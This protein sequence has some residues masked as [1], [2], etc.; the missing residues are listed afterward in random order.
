MPEGNSA[1]LP[2]FAGGSIAGRP[3]V[4]G[5]SGAFL[6]AYFS[7]VNANSFQFGFSIFILGMVI[8]GV[9]IMTGVPGRIKEVL[10]VTFARPRDVVETKTLPRFTE[11]SVHIWRVLESEVR[12]VR[13]G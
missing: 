4:G 3:I 7:S 6:G 2:N 5:I 12:R 9:A 10:D 13:Q 1:L 8:L 11:L